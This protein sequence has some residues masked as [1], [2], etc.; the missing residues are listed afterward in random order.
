MSATVNFRLKCHRDKV[1]QRAINQRIAHHVPSRAWDS[2]V[3]VVV[4]H[5]GAVHH[6]GTASLYQIAI[7]DSS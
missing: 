1:L 7:T 3:T 5:G 2:T 6:I 4:A